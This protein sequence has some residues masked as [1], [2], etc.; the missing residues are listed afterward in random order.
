LQVT[1]RSLDDYLF[2]SI[3]AVSADELQS[4][5][6]LSCGVVAFWIVVRR[7]LSSISV[8]ES[9]AR[10][11]G[12]RVAAVEGRLRAGDRCRDLDLRSHHR[13][14]GGLVHCW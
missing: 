14:A 2:G 6:M 4:V 3:V 11:S 9:M 1:T 5:L 8:D 13:L 10:A 12:V 7:A